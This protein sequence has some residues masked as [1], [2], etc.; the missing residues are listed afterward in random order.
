MQKIITGI[1]VLAVAAALLAPTGSSA[2]EK[3]SNKMPDMSAPFAI[4]AAGDNNGLGKFKK[5]SVN[6]KL[7]QVKGAVTVITGPVAPATDG[8][9]TVKKSNGKEYTFTFDSTSATKYTTFLRKYKGTA[10]WNE[11]MVG[12]AVHVFATKLV[13]GKAI[14]VWDKGIWW[15]EVKGTISNLDATAKSFT[16]T[17]TMKGIDFTTT[18]KTDDATTYRQG[19][20]DK[21][22]TD[23]ANGQKVK[24]RGS[25]NAVGSYLLAK[26]IVIQS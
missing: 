19:D 23:L 13:G 21:A 17:V 20:T 15:A 6:G 16:L 10:T 22:F 25:W 11:I 12:D 4:D 3:K 9:I 7:K 5:H 1:S 26:K 24:V 2:K 8:S 18:V 14:I